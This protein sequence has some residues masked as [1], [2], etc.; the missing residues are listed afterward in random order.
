MIILFQIYGNRRVYHLELTY[1]ILSVLRFLKE[2]KAGIRVV[3]ASDE[4]NS[5]PDLPVEA[6][7]MTPE[8]LH[9]WQMGGTYN[10]AIQ[11]YALHHAVRHFDAPVILVDSDTIFHDH[12][13]RL[14]DRIGPGKMLMHAREGTLRDSDAWPEW[15]SLIDR[16]GGR[17]GGQAVT[18]DS[19]MYN[20]GILGLC[21]SDAD[22]LD[23]VEA[24]M[25]DIR[26]T[27]DMFTAVQLAASLVF[28]QGH[29]STCEDLV[30]HYWD[31]PRAYYHY[32]MQRM[33]PGVLEGKRIADP[34]M[35][36]PPLRRSPPIALRHRVAARAMRMRRAAGPELGYAYLAYRSALSH[37]KSDPDLANVWADAGLAMLTWGTRD[38]NAHPSDFSRFSGK[39]LRS[40]TWM[41]PDLQARWES[42]WSSVKDCNESS[43]SPWT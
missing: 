34:D 30:E 4:A 15:R 21:P 22:R 2:D 23:D 39:Q 5:R 20:A 38:T 19:V 9:R 27:S 7:T 26:A 36:L 32:Q 8:M 24:A 28:D 10:H 43:A 35:P 25:I 31:G 13:R 40:Q 29:V 1:S 3:L 11:A 16:S 42:Y 33:F 41:K 14:F 18:P 6:L 37:R 17:V 12:P